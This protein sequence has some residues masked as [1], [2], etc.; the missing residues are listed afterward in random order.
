MGKRG[1]EE[2]DLNSWVPRMLSS[3]SRWR[4]ISDS[5]LISH[6]VK[7][8]VGGFQAV[9]ITNLIEYGNACIPIN[10]QAR[11]RLGKDFYPYYS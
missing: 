1:T 7:F 2:T 10:D 8:N 5:I 9:L 11:N 3:I 4:A 6:C